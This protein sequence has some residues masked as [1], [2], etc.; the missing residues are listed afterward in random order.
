MRQKTYYI[1]EQLTFQDIIHTIQ[2]DQD[3][4]KAH[5]KAMLV[6]EPDMDRGLIRLILQTLSEELP[7]VK[8]FGMTLLGPIGAEMCL[9]ERTVF[10]LLLFE[11]GTVDVRLIDCTNCTSKDAGERFLQETEHLENRKGIMVM[12]SC[13]SI[14]PSYFLDT[15]AKAL[16]DVVLFGAQAGTKSFTKDESAVFAGTEISSRGI[17][18]ISFCGESMEIHSR[19]CLGF[20]PLGP[21]HTVT[22]MRDE[23]VIKTIDHEPAMN[24]YK[25]YLGINADEYFFENVCAFPLIERTG[26]IDSACVPIGYLENGEL[27][28]SMR[29][30]EGKQVSLSYSK[31]EY[32]LLDSLKYANELAKYQPQAI[33]VIA[34]LN[35]RLFMGNEGANRELNYFKELNQDVAISYGTGEIL[36]KGENGGV[37]NSTLVAVTLREGEPE[38]RPF[39]VVEDPEL[40]KNR[41]NIPQ[42]ER[43]VTFLEQM[44]HELN[45]KLDTLSRIAVIDQ[46]T[47]LANRRRLDQEFDLLMEEV[48]EGGTFSAFMFDLDHFKVVNDTYGHLVGDSVLREISLLVSD[49]IRRSDLLGRWGGE[50]FVCFLCRVNLKNARMIGERIR[51]AVEEHRFDTAGH[52]TISI[53]VTQ[54]GPEDTK[55][56]FYK[57][58]DQALY[59]AKRSGRNCVVAAGLPKPS[60]GQ[61]Q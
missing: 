61:N 22:N 35:R 9:P 48:R 42:N 52:I 11:S 36:Q 19:F 56:T 12:S 4:Q 40:T 27:V 13:T 16:P 32:L 53:G 25:K 2:N 44:T 26:T 37:L 5:E 29:T 15:V 46:L 7:D 23:C 57:R 38:P 41:G 31:P 6:Y 50:E 49:M 54:I 39:P 28:A 59:R 60:C 45:Q 47:G 17:L 24:L 14:L 21:L 30:K 51:G 58:L 3:Y 10:S 33:F 20:R 34:C 43:L 55:N 8:T 1:S 18:G